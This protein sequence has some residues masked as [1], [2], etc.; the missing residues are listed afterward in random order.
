MA[1]VG[2]GPQQRPQALL[3]GRAPMRL[4]SVRRPGDAVGVELL[5]QLEH[6]GRLHRRADL[7]ADRVADAA[8]ELD[9]GAV[10]VAGALADP[11]HVGRAVVPGAGQGVLPGSASS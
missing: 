5:A 3:D 7:A 6:L 4:I 10:E 11:Q 9:V 8:Q 2:D 1:G